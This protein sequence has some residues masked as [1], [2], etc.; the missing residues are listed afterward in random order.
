MTHGDGESLLRDIYVGV[1]QHSATQI[2]AILRGLAEPDV[3]PAVFHCHGGKDR[4]GVVAAVLLLALGVDDE[5]VLDDYQATSVYRQIEHQQD[6]LANMLDS[7][8]SPEAAVAVLGTPRWAMAA[9]V[10]AVAT[11]YGGIDSYL[12]GPAGLTPAE[13]TALRE[14]LVDRRHDLWQPLG[15]EE[16]DKRTGTQ[17][18]ESAG[19][20]EWRVL[21]RTLQTSFK[22]GSMA[23]GVEFAARIGAAADEANHHPDLTITYPRVHV[24]LTTHD[25]DGLTT[26]DVDLARRISAIAV[27][28]GITAEPTR[29]HPTRDRHRRAR[30]RPPS[31]PSGRRCSAT[32][33]T[34]TTTA[35]IPTAAPRRSGSSRWTPHARS[36]TASTST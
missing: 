2:G 34:S 14:Q 9:A 28:L 22:T 32:S 27:E 21:L 1:L 24:L 6:S 26:S 25:A 11:V 13:L 18:S 33:H 5:T 30:H 7:G 8:M 23:K 36:A 12:T 3:A 10:T 20:D 17:V 29:R 35:S 19:L 31:S 16:T 15:M 4:T